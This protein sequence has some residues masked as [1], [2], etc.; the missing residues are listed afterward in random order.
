LGYKLPDCLFLD[1]LE[2][3][4]REIISIAIA[5]A[6]GALARWT[7]S[8]AGCLLL[9]TGFAW[10]TLVVN[11]LGC[12]LIGF[13]VHWGMVGRLPEITR[14]AVT[15]GFLG[16]MTTFSTFSYETIGFLEDGR[17]LTASA[18]IAANVFL[19]LAAT[20]AGLVL[21]RTILGGSA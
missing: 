14:T 10:G 21:A 1:Q 16:A 3:N 7:L 20:V 12:F 4:M 2:L 9:G 17:W 5:G 11:V 13:I 8:R 19:C 15:I 6:L 18:N